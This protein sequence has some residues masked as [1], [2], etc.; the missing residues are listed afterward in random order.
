MHEGGLRWE[1]IASYVVRNRQS[2]DAAARRAERMTSFLCSTRGLGH[3]ERR[4]RGEGGP[5]PGYG[6][7]TRFSVCFDSERRP[8]VSPPMQN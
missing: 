1:D 5:G 6:S 7:C 4:L 2:H 3:V 8:R